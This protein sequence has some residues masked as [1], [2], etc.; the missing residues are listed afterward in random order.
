M[1]NLSKMNILLAFKLGWISY[2]EALTLL[3][4]LED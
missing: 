3:S 2:G 1:T 4:N